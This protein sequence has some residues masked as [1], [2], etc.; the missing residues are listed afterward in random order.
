MK[1]LTGQRPSAAAKLA[2]RLRDA[3]RWQGPVRCLSV[4]SASW[5][6][7]ASVSLLALL[8]TS[9][10]R[11]GEA[12]NAFPTQGVAT[13]GTP[14]NVDDEVAPGI[15]L[16][17]DAQ[18][19]SES[20]EH[21]N[22]AARSGGVFRLAAGNT[23]IPD[24]VIGDDPTGNDLNSQWVVSEIYSGLT[25]IDDTQTPPVQPDLAERFT[26]D[27]SGRR[28]EFTLRDGL[29]FSDG[30]PVTTSDFK[31]SWERALNPRTRSPR[32]AD[33]LGA[34]EGASEVAQGSAAELSGVTVADERVLQI[35]LV[36]PRS[37]FPALLADPVAVVLKRENVESWGIDWASVVYDYGPAVFR[38]QD[39]LPVGTGPFKLVA[40][41]NERGP[42][43]L[44]RNEHYSGRPPYLEGIEII[45]EFAQLD[46]EAW[47][48]RESAA[49]TQEAIDMLFGRPESVEYQRLPTDGPPETRFLVL[50][51][52]LPP[53]DDLHFRRAL[54]AAVAAD[55]HI[56]DHPADSIVTAHGI[57]PPGFPGFDE[58][59]R[60]LD[61]D[62][63]LAET[64]LARSKHADEPV[65]I[66]F[67]PLWHGFLEE[68]F[69]SL[70]ELWA[71]RLGVEAKYSPLS[72]AAYNW[73][74]ED[75]TLQMTG[76]RVT[77][78]YPD[79]YAVFRVFDGT[80]RNSRSSPEA[81]TVSRMLQDAAT[82]QD[83]ALRL[84]KYAELEQHLID[85]A[86]VIPLRWYTGRKSY[87][88]QTWVSG[89]HWPKYGGSKF[90]DVWFDETAPGRELRLP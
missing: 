51:I 78:A 21:P 14:E 40:F 36:E 69:R 79:P 8:G 23:I 18:P 24:P 31:W 44:Q 61:D 68:E 22:G 84:E 70:T 52:S 39:Q 88:Y 46:F 16:V 35:T 9:C 7:L 17:E 87:S 60:L 28:Y 27:G 38:T 77:P 45:T 86:L 19:E 32:A 10:T 56:L 57:V 65:E 20:I 12:P 5:L 6:A 41:N 47:E 29:K 43:V 85:Q 63:D 76:F 11:S 53:F 33:V 15:E 80:F 48:A 25:R 83:A 73:A 75:G 82:E 89:F 49:F 67:E 81:E 58:D 71:D 3:P 42:W 37:D 66:R 62:P 13:R 34:I 90:K 72:G 64:E 74:I 26:L 2:F 30:S 59:V 1:L 55:H 50:N 54:A 4:S